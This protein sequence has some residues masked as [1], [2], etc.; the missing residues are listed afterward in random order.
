MAKWFMITV[1]PLLAACSSGNGDALTLAARL[2]D[3]GGTGLSKEHRDGYISC[4]AEVLSD[5]PG[6][7][8]DAALKAPDVPAIGEMLGSDTLDA[9]VK[10]CR[11]TERLRKPV[12]E[13]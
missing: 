9:Y 2:A 7:Q 5:V 10:A 8:I 1:L 4:G 13:A 11:Q 6:K 12:P 3:E